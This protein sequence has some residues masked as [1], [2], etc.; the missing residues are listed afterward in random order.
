MRKTGKPEKLEDLG[1]A[2][3]RLF[4]DGAAEHRHREVFPATVLN[5]LLIQLGVASHGDAMPT[6]VMLSHCFLVFV[7]QL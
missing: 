2:L 7:V 1:L 4:D 6:V 5:D 3:H